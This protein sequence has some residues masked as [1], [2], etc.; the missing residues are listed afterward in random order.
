M[1]EAREARVEKF[2]VRL[3]SR[4]ARSTARSIRRMEAEKELDLTD[5][6][7]VVLPR[8]DDEIVKAWLMRAVRR[9]GLYPVTRPE[10]Q[11][12]MDPMGPGAMQYGQV[13]VLVAKDEHDREVFARITRVD[14]QTLRYLG[15]MPPLVAIWSDMSAVGSAVAP[16]DQ[17]A[18]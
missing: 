17:T 11:Y 8:R 18:D 14:G 9:Q 3:R 12:E 13:R 15:P 4:L 7:T 2:A 6:R 10:W 5:S 16:T 1:I